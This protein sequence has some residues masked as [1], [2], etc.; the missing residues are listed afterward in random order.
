[1]TRVGQILV[2]LIA[3]FSMLF[4]GFAVTVFT[5]RVNWRDKY[6]ALKKEDEELRKKKQA[7]EQQAQVLTQ[8]IN[9]AITKHKES[10]DI[11]TAAIKVQQT[12]YNELLA[13]YK[14]AREDASKYAEQAKIYGD[15]AATK[16][17][18]AMVLREQLKT[19]RE[20]KEDALK[21]RFDTETQYIELKGNYETLEAR[22]KDLEQR[23]GELEAILV[24]RGISTDPNESTNAAAI[25][26][27]APTVEGLVLKVDP[28]GKFVQLS[29]GS[30]DGLRRGHRLQVFRVKPQG[31]FVAT[32]EIT[33]V[34][35]DQSVARVI[36][37]L[38][39]ANIQEGD[40]VSNRIVASR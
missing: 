22:A 5:T 33:E 1:M 36:P 38:K 17:K 13:N 31:K 28:D 30:D 27:N 11:Y 23:R 4:M 8:D 34:D 12:N 7:L 6:F 26:Q 32:I 20:Q 16:T 24:G 2:M 19:T 29:I 35:P 3:C 39:Q 9:Q 18:E 25:V 21:K 37:N 10:Q 40:L 14:Q 15:Q